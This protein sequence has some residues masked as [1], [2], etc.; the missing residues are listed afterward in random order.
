MLHLRL[1]WRELEGDLSV[2][3]EVLGEQENGGDLA[4]AQVQVQV[5]LVWLW[6]WCGCGVCGGCGVGVG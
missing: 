2:G 3:V 1:R 6:G 5:G 4:C